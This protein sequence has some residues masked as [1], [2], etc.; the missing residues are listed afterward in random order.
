MTVGKIIEAEEYNK[1]RNKIAQVLGPG[2]T[3][4][5]T[6]VAD[7]QFGYGQNL[8][9][10]TVALGNT[11]TKSQWD[12]LRWD[13]FNARVHQTSSTPSIQAVT[14]NSKI[15]STILAYEGF[16]DSAIA[17]RFNIGA[18]QFAIESGTVRSRNFSWSVQVSCEATMQFSNAAQARYFFN[19]G[20]QFL[21]SSSF[22]PNV[23][24]A[25]HTAW[26]NL[27]NSVG[28]Q[29]VDRSRFYSLT[30]SNVQ[31][32]VNSSSGIYANNNFRLFARSNVANNANGTA[33]Q[34]II[35]AQWTDG[36]TDPDPPG[37]LQFPPDDVVNGTLSLTL[38]QRRA[39]TVLQPSGSLFNIASPTYSTTNITGS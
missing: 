29:A 13:I 3:N 39:T 38:Q 4:P 27:L 25:Q 6:S 26:V 8:Q 1:I 21:I 35:R 9:S 20:G 18:N 28:T 34:V 11:V 24:S 12:N 10:S 19:S 17:E 16:A 15:Q 33:T 31:F 14:T 30:N 32:Y 36:Y 7:P 2:G 22:S 23:S 5:L 37:G